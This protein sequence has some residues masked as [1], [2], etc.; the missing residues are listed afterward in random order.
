MD[1]PCRIASRTTRGHLT[2][3]VNDLLLDEDG[4]WV[5]GE[6]RGRRLVK[7]CSPGN[8]AAVRV[9]VPHDPL[10]RS[11][12]LLR[13]PIPW[14][15]PRCG[16]AARRGTPPVGAPASVRLLERSGGASSALPAAGGWSWTSSSASPSPPPLRGGHTM[17]GRGG[18]G[19]RVVIS[20]SPA[21][22]LPWRVSWKLFTA[23]DTDFEEWMELKKS[24]DIF[25][26]FVSFVRYQL[27]FHGF[28]AHAQ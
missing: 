10:P 21:R 9:V 7:K 20:A 5:L 23:V 6:L 3:E 26:S 24:F 4:V 25:I 19:E 11:S 15:R 28:H 27:F 8:Y 2:S 16:L 17:P 18:A 13:W 22:R 14:P 12:F 1:V